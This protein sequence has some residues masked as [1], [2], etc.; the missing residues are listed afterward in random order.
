MDARDAQAL[1]RSMRQVSFVEQQPP[2][3][4]MA[5][6]AILALRLNEGLN[7]EDFRRRFGREPDDVYGDVFGEMTSLGLL[8]RANGHI[9]LT[10][11]GRY[12]ANEVFVR[13]LPD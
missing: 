7:T 2:D 12:L 13:L 9:R 11:R 3:L 8:E 1:L 10:D 5:D 6:T 4:A